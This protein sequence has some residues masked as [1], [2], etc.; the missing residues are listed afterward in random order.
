MTAG[1][2]NISTHDGAPVIEAN[3]IVHSSTA[4]VKKIIRMKCNVKIQLP[5]IPLHC[6]PVIRDGVVQAVLSHVLQVV[7]K[8]RFF[9]YS[10]SLTS[11]IKDAGILSVL[12]LYLNSNAVKIE[13]IWT[14]KAM[15]RKMA[16][17]DINPLECEQILLN[18]LMANV[19]VAKYN[20]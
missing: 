15:L 13:K 4:S 19:D 7:F 12:I 16:M 20:G 2:R 18:V 6:V 10:T 8:E 14:K 9:L 3:L 5:Q 1:I 11:S 17:R